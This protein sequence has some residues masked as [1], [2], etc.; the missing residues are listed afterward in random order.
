M[1]VEE[2]LPWFKEHGKELTDSIRKVHVRFRE[3]LR[4]IVLLATRLRRR[5]LVTPS[6]PVPGLVRVFALESSFFLTLNFK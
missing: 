6:Y 3:S 1:T 4:V 5:G 2:A